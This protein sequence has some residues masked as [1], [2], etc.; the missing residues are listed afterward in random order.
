MALNLLQTVQKNLGFAELKKIDPNTQEIKANRVFEEDKLNQG[1]L[2]AVMIA[3]YKYTRSNEGADC[4]L[5]GDING[6][7]VHT[8]LGGLGDEAALNIADYAHTSKEAAFERM[9]LVGRESVKAIREKNPT[10]LSEVKTMVAAQKPSI[11]MYL[12]A[13][14]Q[15]GNLLNDETLDDRTHKM[16]GPVSGFMNKFGEIFAQSEKSKNEKN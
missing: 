15:M 1:A 7:W 14:L 11:L 16:E 10:S 4:V 13:A 3:L 9:E 2:S 5:H 6:D 12:P 8:M